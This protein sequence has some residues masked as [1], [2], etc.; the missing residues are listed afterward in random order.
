[1]GLDG[2]KL[3]WEL[4]ITRVSPY[5]EDQQVNKDTDTSLRFPEMSKLAT[6]LS[7]IYFTA[8]QFSHLAIAH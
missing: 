6:K 1:M 8:I 3:V 4:F 2:E 5:G 7:E